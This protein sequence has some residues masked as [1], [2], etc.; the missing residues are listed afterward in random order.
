MNRVERKKINMLRLYHDTLASI[1]VM[2]T[3]FAVFWQSLFFIL[4]AIVIFA[5]HLTTFPF[6]LLYIES[7]D[8]F[9]KLWIKLKSKVKLSAK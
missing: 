1:A 7:T 5:I 2:A 9:D 6:M 8:L 3:V 4:Y